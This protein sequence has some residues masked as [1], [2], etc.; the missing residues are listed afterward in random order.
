MVRLALDLAICGVENGINECHLTVFSVD[1]AFTC[2][3][4]A[5]HHPQHSTPIG[6]LVVLSLPV[7]NYLKWQLIKI[8]TH[9]TVGVAI[10][11]L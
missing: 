4:V 2:H 10:D 3:F 11:G 1:V 6:V 5:L 9:S 8:T 7:N